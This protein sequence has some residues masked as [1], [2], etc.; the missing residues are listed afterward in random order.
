MLATA[1]KGFG[2]LQDLVKEMKTVRSNNRSDARDVFGFG[3][4]RMMDN[5]MMN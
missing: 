2:E 5:M 3:G 1:T 4:G